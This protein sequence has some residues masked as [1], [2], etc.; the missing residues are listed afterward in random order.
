MPEFVI[1]QSNIHRILLAANVLSVKYIDDLY[2][3]NSFYANVGGVP[4]KVLNEL[5]T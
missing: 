2:F 4:L 5:E 3:K 1:R